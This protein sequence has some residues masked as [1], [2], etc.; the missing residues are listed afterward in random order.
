MCYAQRFSFVAKYFI[1]QKFDKGIKSMEFI[2]FIEIFQ[3]S[4][5]TRGVLVCKQKVPNKLNS[6]KLDHKQ[7]ERS[8]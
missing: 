4:S 1:V 8:V 3:I 5:F 6:Q 7:L 2:H